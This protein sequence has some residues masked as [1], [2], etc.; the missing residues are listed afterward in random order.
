MEETVQQPPDQNAS[1]NQG[2]G[3]HV[4]DE[5]L[6]RNN[7]LSTLHS[8]HARKID[9][10]VAA[11]IKIFLSPSPPDSPAAASRSC[12]PVLSNDGL[13]QEQKAAAVSLSQQLL[14]TRYDPMFLE[15]KKDTWLLQDVGQQKGQKSDRSSPSFLSFNSQSLTILCFSA[16]NT[17]THSLSVSLSLSLSLSLLHTHIHA[18][19]YAQCNPH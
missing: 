19:W 15:I 11:A 5:I 8:E 1:P 17:H 6:A 3:P 7:Q 16:C 14:S 9:K 12:S 10:Q 2:R 13:P 18:H 4:S